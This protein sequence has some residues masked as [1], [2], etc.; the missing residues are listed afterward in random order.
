MDRTA[1]RV[2]FIEPLVGRGFLGTQRWGE[3]GCIDWWARWLHVRVSGLLFM[4]HRSAFGCLGDGVCLG[5]CVSRSAFG[6]PLSALLPR[7]STWLTRHSPARPSPPSHSRS[8]L[9]FIGS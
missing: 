1:P 4:A 2:H 6:V 5:D 7:S 8:I 9:S 3:S